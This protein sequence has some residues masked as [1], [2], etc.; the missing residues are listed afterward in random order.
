MDA[1]HIDY[2]QWG[3][4]IKELRA[5]VKEMNRRLFVG[6]GSKAM[7]SRVDAVETV[8]ARHE[9]L[10]WFIGTTVSGSLIVSILGL[11]LK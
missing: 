4:V 9:K 3:D 5:E 11:I 10:L 6:N 1:E 7:L 2:C 8:A